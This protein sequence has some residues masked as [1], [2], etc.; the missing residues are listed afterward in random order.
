MAKP[1][2]GRKKVS[3]TGGARIELVAPREWVETLDK[4]AQA[5]GMDRSTFLRVAA[6]EKLAALGWVR[7]GP[8][9]PEREDEE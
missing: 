8:Q 4:A 2:R 7:L 1:R 3:E 6:N 9:A 5:L